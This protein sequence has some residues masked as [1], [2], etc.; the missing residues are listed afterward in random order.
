MVDDPIEEGAF[1]PVDVVGAP[2]ARTDLPNNVA[3]ADSRRAEIAFPNGLHLFFPV[4]L[5]RLLMDRL[6]AAVGSA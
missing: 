5:D 3:E 6:I 4:D 1:I 2:P